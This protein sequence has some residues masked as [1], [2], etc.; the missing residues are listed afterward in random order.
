MM[1]ILKKSSSG[2]RYHFPRWRSQDQYA[3]SAS[4][5]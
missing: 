2:I 1:A 4:G 3:T 5:N